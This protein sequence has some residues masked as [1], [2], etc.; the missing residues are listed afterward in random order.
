MLLLHARKVLLF[1][2]FA[3]FLHILQQ[4]SSL[5]ALERLEAA[6][7]SCNIHPIENRFDSVKKREQ[8][9][10]QTANHRSLASPSEHTH[11][12]DNPKCLGGY[13]STKR[14]TLLT[15]KLSESPSLRLPKPI[16]V[17]GFP[18]AG[19]SSLFT[20]FHCSGLKSM[21][22]FCCD[23]QDDPQAGGP[24]LMA[25]CMLRNLQQNL[26]ILYRCGNFDVY[27]EINGPRK[28]MLNESGH[29]GYLQDDGSFDFNGP[30][31]RIFLPQHYYLDKIHDQYPNSTFV[32]NM[33][34]AGAWTNSV[35]RWGRDLAVQLVNEYHAQSHGRFKLPSNLTEMV[36][37]L[38]AIYN[39]H[40]A[41]VRR[42]VQDHP[43]HALVE[44]NIEDPNADEHLARAFGLDAKCWSHVN[45]N[46]W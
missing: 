26:P 18:K 23:P 6:N 21:H 19:T 8:K 3:N 44:I 40:I 38:T 45:K 32:L 7:S 4:L 17:V 41:T 46:V 27:T 42:F 11:R 16:F 28:F 15:N 43:S 10:Y 35:M 2:S 37:S 39:D 30:G 31:S 29:K 1:V 34:P 22:W 9:G 13:Y 33:R 12:I 5:A 25:S 36:C 20:F 24:Q 14:K